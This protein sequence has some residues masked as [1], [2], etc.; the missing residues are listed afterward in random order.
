MS[1]DPFRLYLDSAR[2]LFS[3]GLSG[4]RIDIISASS[5]TASANFQIVYSDGK[6]L[7]ERIFKDEYS[8]YSD[9]EFDDILVTNDAQAGEWID[10]EVT[11]HDDTFKYD[12]RKDFTIS[13]ISSAVTI[14]SST[15]INVS[16]TTTQGNLDTI[17]STLQSDTALRTPVNVT[18]SSGNKT[19]SG[20]SGTLLA[21]AS[22]ANGAYLRTAS[23][24][25]VSGQL[26]ALYI[27]TAA[28][29]SISDSTAGRICLLRT[30]GGDHIEHPVEVPAGYGVYHISTSS[31]G[32]NVSSISYDLK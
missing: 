6:R 8:A 16:D 21:P 14:D 17:N 24:M 12:R 29:S 11:M 5:K 28:P 9:Q 31:S 22:N 15:A 7:E 23:I 13:E 4:R 2:T 32:Y 20:T 30:N 10:I 25:A 26:A 18:G 27:G 19:V 1:A 3:T